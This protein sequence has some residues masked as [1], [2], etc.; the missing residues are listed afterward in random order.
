MRVCGD[1][2]LGIPLLLQALILIGSKFQEEAL[3]LSI[4][5]AYEYSKVSIASKQQER[6][7]V[8]IDKHVDFV[9]KYPNS[10]YTK[11]AEEYYANS[12]EVLTKFASR[13]N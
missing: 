13:N 9:D 7:Q 5:T 10:A 2:K 3:F 12:T 11:E 4:Q 6:Y 8:V 1:I